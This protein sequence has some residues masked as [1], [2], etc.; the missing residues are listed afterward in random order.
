M[1]YSLTSAWLVSV[2]MT[3]QHTL[4]KTGTMRINTGKLG[5]AVM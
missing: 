2:L 4:P 3:E 1:S 5:A